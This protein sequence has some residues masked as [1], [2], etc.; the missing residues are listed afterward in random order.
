MLKRIETCISVLFF[1]WN[2]W[3][4]TCKQQPL[5]FSTIHNYWTKTMPQY[6]QTIKAV[7]KFVYAFVANNHQTFVTKFL[8]WKHI[9]KICMIISLA[10]KAHSNTVLWLSHLPG[11]YFNLPLKIMQFEVCF[12]SKILCSLFGVIQSLDEKSEY[13]ELE[14]RVWFFGNGVCRT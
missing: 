10:H 2:L 1:Y 11:L 13:D 14:C 12:S 9:F 6:L 3:V 8:G 7:F 5:F 4:V